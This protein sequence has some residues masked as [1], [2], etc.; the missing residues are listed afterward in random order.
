MDFF[1]KFHMLCYQMLLQ[2]SWKWFAACTNFATYND[3]FKVLDKLKIMASSCWKYISVPHP[4]SFM[5]H[6]DKFLTRIKL[7]WGNSY[8]F[9]NSNPYYYYSL[10]GIGIILETRAQKTHLLYVRNTLINPLGGCNPTP[11]SLLCLH[12]IV[13]IVTYETMLMG[14]SVGTQEDLLLWWSI[15]WWAVLCL[16]HINQIWLLNEFKCF[17]WLVAWAL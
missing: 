15:W 14:Q 5:L 17:V 13:M 1:N 8:C 3:V 9:W 2:I 12:K 16:S 11:P 10:M 4:P 6:F 7:C